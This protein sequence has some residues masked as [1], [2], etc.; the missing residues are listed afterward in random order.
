MNGTKEDSTP[1][2]GPVIAALGRSPAD[3][4]L[5]RSASALARESGAPF[6]CVIIDDG[7]VSTQEEGERLAGTLRLARGL[8]ARIA[9]EPG[10]DTAEGLLDYASRRGASA[11][12]VGRTRK[13]LFGRSVVD[14]LISARRG[15]SVLAVSVPSSEA[16]GARKP[17]RIGK[18]RGSAGQYGLALLLVA[19]VTGVNLP[20]AS[21]A[22]YWAAAVPY[23][24]AISLSALVLD[25]WPVLFAALLSAAAWDFLFIPPLF[26]MTISR[27]EDALMLVLYVLVALCSGWMTAMLRRSERLLAAREGRMSR[28]NALAHGLA[29]AG[30][31]EAILGASV[32]AIKEAFSAETIVILRDMDGK[33]KNEAESGWEALDSK[34]REAAR[35]CFEELR[36]SGRFT[37]DCPESEWHFVPIEGS[38]GCLGVIGLRS[39]RG[40][41]WNE[42]LE[43][44]LR[45]MALTVSI[46]AAREMNTSRLPRH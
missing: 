6:D 17:R 43:S 33:L 42:D 22:G 13:K 31:I 15:F 41:A 45:T 35:L 39:A 2:A 29:G 5:V 21:Y 3:D 7:I 36:A 10:I 25:R 30:T 14:R 18:P 38:N 37:K 19:A 4:G 26:T 12:V 27:T 9:S 11:L 34:A 24:A 20:L 16:A 1:G 44:F 40:A 46:A 8:G 23:L 28:L 32:E